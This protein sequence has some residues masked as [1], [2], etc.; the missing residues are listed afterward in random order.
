[1]TNNPIL[2]WSFEMKQP[3]NVINLNLEKLADIS[4]K[5]DE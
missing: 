3:K 2:V 1:M 4:C 5:L